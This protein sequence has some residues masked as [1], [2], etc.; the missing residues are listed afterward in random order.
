MAPS[1]MKSAMEPAEPATVSPGRCR[2][3][4]ESGGAESGS[5]DESDAD[6][7]KND[8]LLWLLGMRVLLHPS[9]C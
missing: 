6:L 2:G 1:L 8:D 7:A 5:R 3:R 4:S 9:I